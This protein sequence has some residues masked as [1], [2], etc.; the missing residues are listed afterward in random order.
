MRTG[1]GRCYKQ[2]RGTLSREARIDRERGRACEVSTVYTVYWAVDYN[3]TTRI[4]LL[5]R[6][7]IWNDRW[8]AILEFLEILRKRADI[9]R[10]SWSSWSR[11]G[12]RDVELWLWYRTSSGIKLPFLVCSW[13]GR[14]ERTVDS[15]AVTSSSGVY[16]SM[17]TVVG[18]CWCGFGSTRNVVGSVDERVCDA[19]RA[20]L[21]IVYYS[22]VLWVV[23][24]VYFILYWMYK[25]LWIW[26]I[27]MRTQWKFNDI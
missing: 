11:K 16:V 21:R 3:N 24:F 7:S 18:R 6:E 1:G 13:R 2:Y 8:D 12:S 19:T 10:W 9:Y 23:T 22:V 14:A 27:C 20:V 15:S 25:I 26:W 17:A 4:D 5:D